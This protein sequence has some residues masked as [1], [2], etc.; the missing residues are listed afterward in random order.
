MDKL[1]VGILWTYQSDR[2]LAI[3]QISVR[4]KQNLIEYF[5]RYDGNDDV[6]RKRKSVVF[7]PFPKSL[8]KL[9]VHEMY[10]KRRCPQTGNVIW[11]V[12]N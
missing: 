11:M 8:F 4:R 3:E 2:K 12:G 5:M 7:L 1:S 9:G 6:E 10:K